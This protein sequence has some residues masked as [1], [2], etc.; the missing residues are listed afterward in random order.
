MFTNINKGLILKLSIIAA[1]GFYLSGCGVK[2][3]PVAHRLAPPTAVNDLIRQM[4][5]DTLKLT[6]TIPK[7]KE[8]IHP[9]LEGFFVYRSQK[10]LSEY[11]CTDCPLK[12]I[13]IA[14]IGKKALKSSAKLTKGRMTYSETLVKGYRYIYKV[15]AYNDNGSRF[16]DSNLVTF[17]Y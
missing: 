8:K 5:E 14:D 17:H 10:P 9:D 15:V 12:F 13:L 11:E 2:G 3:P 7:H 4:Q 1:F 6:W 16:G